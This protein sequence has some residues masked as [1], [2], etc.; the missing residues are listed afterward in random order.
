MGQTRSALSHTADIPSGAEWKTG[1]AAQRLR[2]CGVRNGEKRRTHQSNR[3]PMKNKV[4]S[5]LGRRKRDSPTEAAS[6]CGNE[7]GD[8]AARREHRVGKL[9]RDAVV[10]AVEEHGASPPGGFESPSGLE[11]NVEAVQHVV[12][13]EAAAGSSDEAGGAGCEEPHSQR[14][15]DASGPPTTAMEDQ[16]RGGS[17]RGRVVSEALSPDTLLP[18][19]AEG[20]FSGL[21]PDQPL[22]RGQT[23]TDVPAEGNVTKRGCSNVSGRAQAA[24]DPSKCCPV[25][26]R[27][28]SDQPPRGP[29][30]GHGFQ[31]LIP[32]L[33]ITR[34]PS[35]TRS[36]GTP[37]PLSVRSELSSGSCLDPHP[38]DESP[39]SDSGC[40]G[41]PAL[42]RSLRK[43]SNSS[44]I[45]LSSASS[46]EESEDDFTGSDIESSLSPA[47]SMCG[48][49]DGMGNKS[50]QKLKTMVH[51]SPFVVSF[52][53][54]YP[55]V[56]LAG[57]AGNFQAG[58]YGRLLKRY[59]ECEQQC[60]QKLMK[61]TLRPYVPGYYGIVQ[62]EE[63][64]YN[65]MDDL[66]A[67]FDSPSIMDCKMGSRT[68]L[69]EELSKARERPRLRKDMYEKMVAVDP[70]APTEQERAQQG[71][72]KPRYMQWRETLS[73]TDTL[74]F[75]IE[76]I[77]KA[78]G[79]CN[80]NFKKTKHREQV[81]Q[82][83]EDFVAGN[84]QILKLYLQR[85]EE[86]RSALEQSH[87]FRTHEVVG[88]SLLFVHDASGKAKVWMIDFG[89][90]VPLPDP[91]TLDHRT[92]WMEGNREDGYLWGL[93]N[94]IEIFSTVLPQT[95]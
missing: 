79:T 91:Q 29:P 38:D 36:Q 66:L 95:L 17:E 28:D 32:K 7:A 64:D 33:I 78:D 39:C 71:V 83:L 51:R 24:G 76:G 88:S 53:K 65:L 42:M 10:S 50:W 6:G 56:Q 93:D 5:C 62:R 34:D 15:D 20:T 40:G 37:P 67:D 63:Q 82:A 77:K 73:S 19:D 8:P 44:S 22:D 55:W 3:N 31:G 58:E 2:V 68:Y 21:S 70:G 25:E 26:S 69:E 61:D 87:L 80:T 43:L 49:D 60:L 81:M 47:R 89:K 18:S 4:L 72:L 74:G 46:F 23:L 9:P 27:T 12:N 48:P 86:L 35:P 90:T 52:K 14:E 94:L 85:L 84:T 45:G 92:P 59:C 16:P 41:S 13:R 1:E 75:R 11:N 54:R 30:E 57:H